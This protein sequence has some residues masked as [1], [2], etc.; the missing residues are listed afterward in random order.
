M[1]LKIAPATKYGPNIVECH[2]GTGAIEKSKET[3][4]CTDTATGMIAIAMIDIADS[5][6]C[7]CFGV[8]CQPS[9]SAAYTFCRTPVVLSRTSAKSGIIGSTRKRTLPIRYVLMGSEIPYERRPEIRP[10]LP[11][12]R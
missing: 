2:I 12:A 11:V 5:R 9:A 3:I 8:P 1:P 6:R 10:D 7:H 4:V